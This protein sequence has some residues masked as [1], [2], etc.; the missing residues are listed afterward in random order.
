[1]IDATV[2]HLW[3][4]T[5]QLLTWEILFLS[6]RLEIPMLR[7]QF[8]YANLLEETKVKAKY[9]HQYCYGCKATNSAEDNMLH[10]R[11]CWG[12]VRCTGT[13]VVCE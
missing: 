7:G 12:Y 6:T 5:Q 3:G 9:N 11:A 10:I 8:G 4:L 1:M 2:H 13:I